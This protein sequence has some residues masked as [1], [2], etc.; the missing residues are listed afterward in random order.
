MLF[1]VAQATLSVQHNA[2]HGQAAK[3]SPLFQLA[4]AF[5]QPDVDGFFS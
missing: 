5:R 4:E 2:V 3:K 1:L